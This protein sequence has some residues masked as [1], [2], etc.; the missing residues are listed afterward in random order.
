MLAIKSLFSFDHFLLFSCD[1]NAY[2]GRDIVRRNWMLITLKGQRVDN[3]NEQMGNYIIKTDK[4]KLCKK[5]GIHE[6]VNRKLTT[7]IISFQ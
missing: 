6:S 1:L 7:F 4:L 3:D 5:Q 2:F